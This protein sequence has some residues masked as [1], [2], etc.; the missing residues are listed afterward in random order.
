[1]AAWDD[2][3]VSSEG[4]YWTLAH[5]D[6]GSRQNGWELVRER[7]ENVMKP[8]GPRLFVVNTCRQIIRTVPA[9]LRDEIDMDDADS[10]AEDRVGGWD[11]PSGRGKA[12]FRSRSGRRFPCGTRGFGIMTNI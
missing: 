4:A 1:M 7:L 9:L 3:A 10:K 12:R 2:V 5:N 6:P 11:S 8:E